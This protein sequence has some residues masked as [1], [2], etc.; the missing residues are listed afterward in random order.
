MNAQIIDYNYGCSLQMY[1]P[2]ID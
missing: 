1:L 2:A